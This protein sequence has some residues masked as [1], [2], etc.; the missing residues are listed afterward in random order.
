[1]INGLEA[2]EEEPVQISDRLMQEMAFL[3]A[4]CVAP[5]SGASDFEDE[6][7]RDSFL[8]STRGGALLMPDP[9]LT[10][11]AEDGGSPSFRESQLIKVDLEGAA[12]EDEDWDEVSL[13][14]LEAQKKLERLLR[15]TNPILKRC[16]KKL[17]AE[18]AHWATNRALNEADDEVSEVLCR[19]FVWFLGE[20]VRRLV[21]GLNSEIK[22]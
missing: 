20:S 4:D 7:S 5:V 13:E 6:E 22:L 12:A 14:L 9:D 18:H 3:L 8:D 17:E 2:E 1:M 10:M 15:K 19:V 11:R 21:F 16:K